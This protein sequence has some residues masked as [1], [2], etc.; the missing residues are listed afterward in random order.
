MKPG[1]SLEQRRV[2]ES[3]PGEELGTELQA[4]R[5]ACTW[6]PGAWRARYEWSLWSRAGW[7]WG[8]GRGKDEPILLDSRFSETL[9]ILSVNIQSQFTDTK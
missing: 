6:K 1:L 4:E 8:I 5:T 3:Q 2:E 9:V 7:G